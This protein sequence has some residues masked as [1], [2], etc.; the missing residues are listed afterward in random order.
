MYQVILTQIQNQCL[1]S[2]SMFPFEGEGGFKTG[3][4]NISFLRHSTLCAIP[5]GP[6]IFVYSFSQTDKF[7][8]LVDGCVM[9]KWLSG[10]NSK[11][12]TY[13]LKIQF[14]GL[15]FIQTIFIDIGSCV[16]HYCYT[17]AKKVE[18]IRR[19]P[20]HGVAALS[21]VGIEQGNPFRDCI[22][23]LLSDLEG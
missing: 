3:K 14:S 9:T 7:R 11:Q 10:W 8:L 1:P 23:S 21:A 17:L 4:S 13:S 18:R 19:I 15:T 2:L 20:S 22:D 16:K 6:S 12:N 5:K